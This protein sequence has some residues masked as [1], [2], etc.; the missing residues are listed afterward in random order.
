MSTTT[1]GLSWW[2]LPRAAQLYVAAVVAAG[3]YMLAW[4]LPTT[5]PEPLMFV[6]LLLAA[7]ITSTW[8]VTL[9]ISA[10]GESTLSVSYAAHLMALL[11]LGPKHAVLI[12]VTGACAQC[13]LNVKGRYPAYCTVFSMAAEALTMATTGFVYLSLGGTIG[14]FDLSALPK[15]LVGGIATYFVLNTGLVAAAI[16]VSTRRRLWRVW[17]A[18]FLWSASSF[19]VAGTAGALA[20][21]IIA[22]GEQWTALVMLA[23]VYLTYGTYRMFIGRLEDQ[24]R[25]EQALSEEK[26]RERAARASAEEANRLKDEFLAMVSHELR[27]PLTAIVG[28][29]EMLRG[30]KLENGRRDRACQVIYDSARRQA[31]MID[32]LLDVSR[33]VSGKLAVNRTAVDLAGVVGDA[34]EV[35]QPSAVVKGIHLS[36]NVDPALGSIHGD[37]DRLQQI[38]W[39]LLSN[40]VKFTPDGG[41]VHV[42]ARRLNTAI[43]E[44]VVADN[45]PGIPREFL[46]SVFEPFRQG[47]G[48]TT[49]QHGGLGLGLAIVKHLVEAHGGT[50]SADNDADGRGARFTVRLPMLPVPAQPRPLADLQSVP[51]LDGVSVLLVDDDEESRQ[52]IAAHLEDHRAH[53]LTAGSAGAALDLLQRERVDVLVADIAMPGEDGYALLR[54]VRASSTSD[55]ATVPAVALTALARDEDRVQAL[56]AG[57]QMHLT[58]PIETTTLIAAVSTLGRLAT[59]SAMAAG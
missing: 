9:P 56:Q 33:I 42:R 8:K 44:L 35:V 38:V 37:A 32:E 46:P 43:A 26:E 52:V 29:A 57:F 36:M 14:T 5:Y 22:R 50:V 25:H 55:V 20:A 24:K 19:M 45:G 13:T 47:D 15:P 31:Q 58:K 1:H 17:R 51:T 53:V 3:A 21:V 11:L 30:G 48:S 10:A 27:T 49:R 18:D 59:Q 7:C 2:A 41:T 40:A 54:R 34:L 12:A 23:P 4:C 28:W 39:N 6:L 16:A